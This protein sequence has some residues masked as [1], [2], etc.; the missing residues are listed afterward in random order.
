[1]RHGRVDQSGKAWIAAHE[2]RSYIEDYNSAP[3]IPPTTGCPPLCD[4]PFVLCSSLRRSTDSAGLR[5]GRHERSDAIFNEA[6]LPDVPLPPLPAA[7]LMLLARISWFLGRSK[8]CEP[9]AAFKTRVQDAA[10]ALIDLSKDHK[11]VVLVGHGMLNRSIAKYLLSAGY[12]GPKRPAS[13]HWAC[14]A[15][16]P[17]TERANSKN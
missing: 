17:A 16:S 5:F 6:G 3:I 7:V 4:A 14:T 12:T 8:G 11:C 2:L 10:L 9:Y 13:K 1:M 15:Y